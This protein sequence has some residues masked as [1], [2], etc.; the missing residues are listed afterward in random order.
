MKTRHARVGITK[1]F[2]TWRMNWHFYCMVFLFLHKHVFYNR[3]IRYIFL[4]LLRVSIKYSSYF[5][6]TVDLQDANNLLTIGKNSRLG[7]K[8]ILSTHLAFSPTVIIF[9]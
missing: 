2:F 3:T 5:A 6:E 9:R 1:Q 8:V 4:R 7:S